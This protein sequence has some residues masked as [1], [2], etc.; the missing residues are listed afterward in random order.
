MSEKMNGNE[1]KKC[2]NFSGCNAPLCPLES[3]PRHRFAP[4]YP[5]QE[6][7]CR[8]DAPPWVQVQKRIAKVVDDNDDPGFFTI[9]TL[10][11]TKRVRKGIKGKNPD[12][13]Q[14]TPLQQWERKQGTK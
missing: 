5:G 2:W 14:D 6:I 13:P 10:M 8:R 3:D 4:W 12:W 7:C 1:M 9:D 11:E